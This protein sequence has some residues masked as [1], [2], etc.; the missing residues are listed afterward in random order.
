MAD[1]FDK[2]EEERL[3]KSLTKKQNPTLSAE[4]ARKKKEAEQ[5]RKAEQE[6]RKQMEEEEIRKKKFEEETK[7]KKMEE[8]LREKQKEEEIQKQQQLQSRQQEEQKIREHQ[9]QQLQ[10]LNEETKQRKKEEEPPIQN[11]ELEDEALRKE[12]ARM[13]KMFG[14]LGL[15]PDKLIHNE[16]KKT[17]A[18][19]SKIV[20]SDTSHKKVSEPLKQ[21]IKQDQY[22]SETAPLPAHSTT[23][24]PIDE[25]LVVDSTTLNFDDDEERRARIEEERMARLLSGKQHHWTRGGPTREELEQIEKEKQLRDLKEKIDILGASATN[26]PKTFSKAFLTDPEMSARLKEASGLKAEQKL[27]GLEI[28]GGHQFS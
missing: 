23:T 15:T 2:R 21:L 17:E 22:Q 25:R 27:A 18:S 4:E 26:D 1:D 10:Q 7:K 24:A 28:P 12:A 16:K 11:S 8:Y 20:V 6:R 9:Q 14:G 5:K 13:A 19:S 3:R